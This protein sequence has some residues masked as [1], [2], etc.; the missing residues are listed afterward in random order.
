MQ[1]RSSL[2]VSLFLLYIKTETFFMH[3]VCFYLT[4]FSTGT[5]TSLGMK[6][7]SFWAVKEITRNDSA[8]EEL[9]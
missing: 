4:C 5:E 1:N 6:K 8:G 2:I 7:V 9:I 3:Y